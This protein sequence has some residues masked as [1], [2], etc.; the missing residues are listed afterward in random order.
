M[1]NGINR[2]DE[3]AKPSLLQ[4]LN[5]SRRS[6]FPAASRIGAGTNRCSNSHT[7]VVTPD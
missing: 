7:V 3:V 5:S 6:T 2:H 4:T 1:G